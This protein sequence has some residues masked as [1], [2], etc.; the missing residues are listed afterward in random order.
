[1]SRPGGTGGLRI[2]VVTNVGQPVLHAYLSPLAALEDV[3]E[4]VV[5]RD[6]S[7]VQLPP[8]VRVATPP[9]WWPHTTLFEM[10]SRAYILRRETA[11]R[12]AHLLMTVHWFPDGPGVLRA[13]RRLGVPVVANLIGGRAEMIDGGRRLALSRLPR[14]FKRWAERYQRGRLNATTVITCTGNATCSWLRAAGVVRPKLMTLHA[15][16]DGAWFRDAPAARDIDVA[17][18]GRVNP[19]KRVDRMLNVLTAIGRRRRGTRV[20]VVSQTEADRA[21]LGGYRELITA[22]AALGD[23]LRLL[24]RVERVSDVLRRAK[25]LLLT[26]DTEGRTLA[27]LEAMACGAVPVVTDVGDLTEALDEG[28]AGITIPLGA[29]EESV[30]AALGDAVVSLLEDEARRQALAAR[31]REWVR[32]EHDPTRTREEWRAVIRHALT[33]GDTPCASS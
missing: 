13:A 15:A 8:K 19:D 29:N 26:S 23:G 12:R 32:R 28:R 9:S 16:L 21:D 7:D 22:R 5:V 25:V 11:R 3:A 24:G 14:A 4:I 33:S 1:M 30:V 2:V 20:A 27:V 6:R 31:A 10:I 18:V 17:Y